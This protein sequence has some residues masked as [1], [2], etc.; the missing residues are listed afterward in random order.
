MDLHA[1]PD[2]PGH[3][4]AEV[5]NYSASQT[6]R[7]TR[8]TGTL[9]EVLPSAGFP[10]PSKPRTRAKRFYAPPLDRSRPTPSIPVV[11]AHGGTRK[12]M[13]LPCHPSPS[14]CGS[15]PCP[16]HVFRRPRR[17]PSQPH[18]RT[19]QSGNGPHGTC[20]AKPVRKS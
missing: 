15:A 12:V 16:L 1:I 17:T 2:A 9:S 20:L 11:D 10:T 6:T 3:I 13:H 7:V 14:C 18:T 19:V 5:G 8:R 4:P